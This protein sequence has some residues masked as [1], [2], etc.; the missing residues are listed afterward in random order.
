MN[1]AISMTGWRRPAYFERVLESIIAA[2]GT[3]YPIHISIDG[4]YAESQKLMRECV[5]HNLPNASVYAHTENLGCAS[6]THYALARAFQDPSIDAVIHLEDDTILHPQFFEFMH[7]ALERYA[8]QPRIFSVSGY[9]RRAN[10]RTGGLM[11]TEDWGGNNV[12]LQALFTCWGWGTWRRV[13]EEVKDEWFGIHWIGNKEPEGV[14]GQ[15]FMD[16]IVKNPKGSWAHPM[17]LHWRGQRLEIIPDESLVQN[18]GVAHST[19][20]AG[21]RSVLQHT[22]SFDTTCIYDGWDFDMADMELEVE[23]FEHRPVDS[24]PVEWWESL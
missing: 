6:N 21:L 23:A 4:G 2:N 5:K 1:I 24:R 8:N 19:F 3:E 16:S 15:N 22:D 9:K 13:W 11:L 18:I 14:Q 20:A 10:Q 17:N 7:Q 12:G